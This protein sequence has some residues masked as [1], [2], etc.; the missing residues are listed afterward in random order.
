MHCIH[1]E[2]HSLSLHSYPYSYTTSHLY[3]A[4]IFEKQLGIL[5]VDRYNISNSVK[6]LETSHSRHFWFNSVTEY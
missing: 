1:A 5:N 4:K 6:S 3:V 2:L